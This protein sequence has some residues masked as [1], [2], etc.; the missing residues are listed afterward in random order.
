[1]PLLYSY[2]YFCPV[3]ESAS[4]GKSVV[5]SKISNSEL[6]TASQA[7]STQEDSYQTVDQVQP[8][9][10]VRNNSGRNSTGNGR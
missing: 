9:F 1:V 3:V 4:H 7:E 10:N 6:E 8:F 2:F 5:L